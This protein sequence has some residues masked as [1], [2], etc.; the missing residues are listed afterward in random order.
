MASTNGQELA[1]PIQVRVLTLAF[2]Q[3]LGGFDERPLRA[4]VAGRE[5]LEVRE[6]CVTVNGAPY[7]ACLC[8]LRGGGDAPR[9]GERRREEPELEGEARELFQTLRA[10]RS[11]RSRTDGV[12]PYVIFNNRELAAIASERPRSRSALLG[13]NGVG[14]G[15]LERYGAE[16]LAMLGG[17]G[18]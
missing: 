16:L 2:S 15:K 12:P 10:W 7:L 11:E 4:L 17:D 14:E 8:V 18:A 3:S 1:P 9:G 5:V 13:L 6:H